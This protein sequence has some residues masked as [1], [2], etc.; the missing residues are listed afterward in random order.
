M[1][2]KITGLAINKNYE[3]DFK[4]LQEELGWNLE[5]QSEIDF[6]TAISDR[7]EEGFCE[8]FFLEKGTLLFF[9]PKM[10]HE[11]FVLQNTNIL[12]FTLLDMFMMYHINYY[13]NGIEIR[14]LIDV[15]EKIIRDE[16]NKF[17][18]EE[19]ADEYSEIILR[20]IEV[21]IGKSLTDIE[22]SKKGIRYTFIK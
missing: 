9:T 12:N 1:S 22:P 13:E 11:V 14:S 4:E 16:G 5:K 2:Y 8:V 21:V 19:Y 7:T 10:R 18:G 17:D 3:N 20:Q 6:E 15:N